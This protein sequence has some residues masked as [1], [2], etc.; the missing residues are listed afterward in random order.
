MNMK[1]S[2]SSAVLAGGAPFPLEVT[3]QAIIYF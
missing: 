3:A 1:I 2:N